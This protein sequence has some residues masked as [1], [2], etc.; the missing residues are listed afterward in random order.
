MN[1]KRGDLWLIAT[2]TLNTAIDKGYRLQQLRTGQVN[3]VLD[4]TE[5]PGGKGINV[6]RVAAMLGSHVEVSGF[7]GEKHLDFFTQNLETYGIVSNLITV[8]GYSRTT[9]A[10]RADDTIGVTEFLEKGSA[11]PEAR[12]APLLQEVEQLAARSRVICFSGSISPGLPLD[13]YATLIRIAKAKGA[14]TMLDTSGEALAYGLKAQPDVCKPNREELEQLCGKPLERLQDVVAAA[15]QLVRSGVGTVIVSLDKDGCVAAS[16]RAVY[17][18]MPPSIHP[19]NT[20]GCGD[21]LVAGIAHVISEAPAIS[22]DVWKQALVMGTAAAASNAMQELAGH[23]DID[24]VRQFADR[25][26]VSEVEIDE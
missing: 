9:I 19:V 24:Q 21:S 1:W 17:L 8:P 18:A 6:A 10:V 12:I 5:I 23:I 13:I 11:I 20:V 7:V 26:K 22:Q 16:R 14:L 2:V 25:V 15:K 3:R 4:V